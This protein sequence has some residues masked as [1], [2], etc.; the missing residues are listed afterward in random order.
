ML[1]RSNPYE[2]VTLLMLD[3]AMTPA[4]IY[5]IADNKA[6]QLNKLKELSW[7]PINITYATS[8]M[9][10][11]SMTL[12]FKGIDNF[13]SP[14]YL[15]DSE[16]QQRY[17]LTNNMELT[18]EL[19][20]SNALR[21]Y[22]YKMPINDTAIPETNN[23]GIICFNPSP[24]HLTVLATDNIENITIYNSIGQQVYQALEI[25]APLHNTTLSQGSYVIMIKTRLDQRTQKIII[26]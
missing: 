13:E 19:P 23:C 15:M 4:A 20:N 14:L 17:L 18:L 21:Y 26:Q 2:D 22:I 9:N 24:N 11:T 8:L 16:L 6:L 1:F 12:S 25:R 10:A 5:T 7:L 3:S